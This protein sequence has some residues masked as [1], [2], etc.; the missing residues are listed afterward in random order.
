[1]DSVIPPALD[2]MDAN[3]LAVIQPRL[4]MKQCVLYGK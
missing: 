4:F 3:N 2:N 1:M